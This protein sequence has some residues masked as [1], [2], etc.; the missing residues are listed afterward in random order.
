MK[1]LFVSGNLLN[2]VSVKKFVSKI[3]I[4]KNS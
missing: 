1:H 3:S 2:P 4:E